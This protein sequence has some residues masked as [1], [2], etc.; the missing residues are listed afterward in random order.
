MLLNKFSGWV[1]I[2]LFLW[3][4]LPSQE[5][6]QEMRPFVQLQ[7]TV[8]IMMFK[9]PVFNEENN[10]LLRT[11]QMTDQ[12]ITQLPMGSGTIIHPDGLILTNHHVYKMERRIRYDN[13]SNQLQ[14]IEPASRSLIVYGLADND[15]LKSP[16]MQYTAKPV[17]LDEKHDTALLQIVGDAEGNS[18]EQISF[19]FVEIG[20]PFSLPLNSRLLILG[21]PSKGGKTITVSDGK[22]LGYYMNDQYG[23]LD[24]FIKSDAA[25]SPGNSGGSALHQSR[26]IGV[27]TAVTLPTLAGSDMGYIHPVTWAVKVLAIAENKFNLD[28]PEIPLEWLQRDYNSDETVKNIYLSGELISAQSKEPISAAV[29]VTRTDRTFDQIRRLHLELQGV[30]VVFMFQQMY[31][32]GAKA[33]DI[34]AYFDIPIAAVRQII[35]RNISKQDLSSDAQQVLEGE[36]Y[37]QVA[38]SDEDGFFVL[39][40]PREQQLKFHGFHK[41]FHALSRSIRSNAGTS[42][43]LGS[44]YLYRQ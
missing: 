32:A 6:P 27:P 17:A 42:Q 35:S 43:H 20:D 41:G 8:N 13:D 30:V 14:I 16:V 5:I 3:Q 38:Q 39:S 25:M 37:Y 7:R 9:N 36:F 24:G 15:P 11:G 40:I 26:L 1:L 4:N 22:F 10:Q 12:K 2:F 29:M 18:I 44:L 34:A 21:Y 19:P 31:K 28:V 23:G 33:E